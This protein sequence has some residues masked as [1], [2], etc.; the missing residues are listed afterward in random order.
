MK[1]MHNLLYPCVC[2]YE[3]LYTSGNMAR[4]M[5][6]NSTDLLDGPHGNT[7]ASMLWLTLKTERLT[8]SL[9]NTLLRLRLSLEHLNISLLFL[10]LLL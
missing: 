4:P 5:Y 9:S 7:V 2:A 6:T 1:K 8:P 3:C 10:L